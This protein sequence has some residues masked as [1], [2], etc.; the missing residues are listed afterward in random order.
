MYLDTE[1]GTHVRRRTLT[2]SWGFSELVELPRPLRRRLLAPLPTRLALRKLRPGRVMQHRSSC[3]VRH[4]R[5]FWNSSPPTRFLTGCSTV[6]RSLSHFVPSLHLSVSATCSALPARGAQSRRGSGYQLR[7][8]SASHK[9]LRRAPGSFSDVGGL[10]LLALSYPWWSATHP[11]PQGQQLQLL[12][13]LL[14]AIV[15]ALDELGDNS[16]WGVLWD[17]ASLPQRGYTNPESSSMAHDAAEDRSA[18]QLAR[19][20]LGLRNINVWYTHKRV[21]TLLLNTPTPEG[22]SNQQPYDGRGWCIF[23]QSISSLVK[24]ANN[25]ISMRRYDCNSISWCDIT[26]QCKE[27]RLPPLGPEAFATR[28]RRGVEDGTVKF[29]SGSDLEKVVLPNYARGFRAAFNAAHSLNYGK[30]G[31]TDMEAEVLAATLSE[32]AR[33]GVGSWVQ[34]LW[35]DGNSLIGD[36]GCLFLVNALADGALSKLQKLSFYGCSVGGP[37]CA[38]L[39]RLLNQGS[40]PALKAVWV[41]WHDKREGSR[42]VHSGGVLVNIGFERCEGVSDLKRAAS[43]RGIGL[44]VRPRQD[45]D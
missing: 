7:H 37:G 33:D 45:D 43:V 39:A 30:L 1:F 4:T 13:P 18:L 9:C 19:F 5:R 36:S 41:S 24:G 38:A 14:E 23:E 3:S 10:P 35:L 40:L 22:A 6:A 26:E 25:L 28:L 16:T 32:M 42:E 2:V 15:K 34:E 11:D 8:L 17:F 27:G 20:R 29:T 31:W 12:L 21:W 44:Y